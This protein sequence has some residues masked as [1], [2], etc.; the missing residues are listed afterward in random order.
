MVFEGFSVIWKAILR[1]KVENGLRHDQLIPAPS[2][3]AWRKESLVATR[4][5]ILNPNPSGQPLKLVEATAYFGQILGL[6]G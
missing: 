6:N 3:I 1:K 4:Y 5:L 2:L